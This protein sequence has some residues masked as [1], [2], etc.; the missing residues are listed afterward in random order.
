MSRDARGASGVGSLASYSL[1][2]NLNSLVF[3]LTIF[4]VLIAVLNRSCQLALLSGSLRAHP[5]S[6]G[7]PAPSAGLMVAVA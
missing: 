3:V 7:Q 4:I 5:I 2:V 6:L 1:G